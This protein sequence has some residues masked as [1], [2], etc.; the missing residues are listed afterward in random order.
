MNSEGDIVLVWA[1]M[2]SLGYH[3]AIGISSAHSIAGRRYIYRRF[4]RWR[5]R[6]CLSSWKCGPKRRYHD[7]RNF[8]NDRNLNPMRERSNDQHSIQEY[9]QR[10]DFGSD[11]KS[12]LS[13]MGLCPGKNCKY[14]QYWRLLLLSTPV[15]KIYETRFYILYS[16]IPSNITLHRVHITHTHCT[17]RMNTDEWEEKNTELQMKREI[18]LRY[19]LCM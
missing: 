8:W 14:A 16:M 15:G 17:H 1:R 13:P 2:W 9:N 18:Y 19:F 12:L 10:N 4:G 6:R 11:K 5:I 3:Q 7:V